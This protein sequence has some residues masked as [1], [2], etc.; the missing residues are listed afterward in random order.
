[1]T[2][3]FV[4]AGTPKAIVDPLHGNLG[5][6]ERARHEGK[7]AA[8]RRRGGGQPPA[9]FAAYVK[10]DVAKWKKVITDAKIPHIGG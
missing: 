9:D 3:V 4:P 10:A 6:R 8:G 5:D 1:M 7:V 2:G